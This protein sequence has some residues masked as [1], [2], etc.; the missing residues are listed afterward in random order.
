MVEVNKI[1]EDDFSF[2][3]AGQSAKRLDYFRKDMGAQNKMKLIWKDL[4]EWNFFKGWI[5]W[6]SFAL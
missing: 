5:L 1:R 3:Q 6:R 2:A 4:E